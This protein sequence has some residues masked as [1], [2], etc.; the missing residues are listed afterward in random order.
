[1]KQAK[2][3]VEILIIL[4]VILSSSAVVLYL[5]TEGIIPV[6]GQ[7]QKSMLN[8][9]FL[10]H[11]RDGSI[12]LKDFSFCED[13]DKEFNCLSETEDFDF[14]DEVHFRYVIE[15]AT[16]NGE[17]KVIKNYRIKAPD[18]SVIIDAEGDDNFHFD[19]FSNERKELIT[20]ADYFIINDGPSGEYTLE[21]ILENPLLAK[22]T[23]LSKRFE[24]G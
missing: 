3:A 17:I 24:V 1:M 16:Y 2:I 22:K 18:G 13:V 12:A 8:T 21:L 4:I 11:V 14:G 5:A 19:V 23:T 10:P 7:T 15:T 20:F 6:K 9:E